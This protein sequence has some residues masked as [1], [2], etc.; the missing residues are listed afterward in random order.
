MKGLHCTKKKT[1]KELYNLY[2]NNYHAHIESIQIY[3]KNLHFSSVYEI[4]LVELC[5]ISTT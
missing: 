3:F 5:E 2:S 1:F 4:N